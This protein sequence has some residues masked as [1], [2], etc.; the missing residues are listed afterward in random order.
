MLDLGNSPEIVRYKGIILSL[1]SQY[2]NG[3]DFDDL[4]QAGVNGMYHAIAT[5][6]K[7]HKTKLSTHIFI[8]ARQYIQLAKNSEVLVSC[9]PST[10][11]KHN[12]HI[13]EYNDIS[14]PHESYDITPLDT[15]I[16]KE[17]NQLSIALYKKLWSLLNRK[18]NKK[19]R[20]IIIDYFING[21]SINKLNK[22]YSTNAY[23]TITYAISIIKER[24]NDDYSSSLL[25][26]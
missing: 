25:D 19:E 26:N 23:K 21:L 1:V 10:R 14:V 16:D 5:F 13:E 22:K 18:F 24:L 7:K 12:I 15:L 9:H 6:K 17:N 2:T 11:I 4:L 8:H 20:K 3:N